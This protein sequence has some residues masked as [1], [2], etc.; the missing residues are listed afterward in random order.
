MR[1]FVR[2]KLNQAGS[3]VIVIPTFLI[4]MI[5]ILSYLFCIPGFWTNC[6]QQFCETIHFAVT[7]DIASFYSNVKYHLPHLG[8]TY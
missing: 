4:V 2:K 3:I 8:G 5:G 6:S 1:Q 7:G